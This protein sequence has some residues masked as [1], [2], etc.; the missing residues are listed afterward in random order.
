MATAEAPSMIAYGSSRSCTRM[1]AI[2][3]DNFSIDAHQI[4]TLRMN[5]RLFKRVHIQNSLLIKNDDIRVHPLQDQSFVFHSQTPRRIEGHLADGLLQCEN[6]LLSDVS[7]QKTG[8]R[9][10][11]PG[12]GLLTAQQAI[13]Y[14]AH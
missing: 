3:H 6:M 13:R 11:G 4:N 2:T 14:H 12:M 8:K 7:G 1:H 10:I 9:R 5:A